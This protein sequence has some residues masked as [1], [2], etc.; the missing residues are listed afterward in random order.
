M[1]GIL[2]SS[3]AIPRTWAVPTLLPSRICAPPIVFAQR[4]RIY[5]GTALECTCSVRSAYREVVLMSRIEKLKLSQTN[6]TSTRRM[7]RIARQIAELDA[8][9]LAGQI[10]AK[11]RQA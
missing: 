6:E 1:I 3:H 4:D 9:K 5:G 11:L 8:E 7:N 2:L 10:K